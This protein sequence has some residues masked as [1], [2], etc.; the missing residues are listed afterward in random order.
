MLSLIGTA[1]EH[2]E[3]LLARARA[4]EAATARAG[5]SA[6]ALAGQWAPSATASPLGDAELAKQPI[7]GRVF[8][9]LCPAVDMTDL[10]PSGPP[11]EGGSVSSASASAGQCAA[12]SASAGS[13]RVGAAGQCAA[14]A[15]VGVDEDESGGVSTDDSYTY[16]YREEAAQLPSQPPGQRPAG[17]GAKQ[18]PAGLATGPGGARPAANARVAPTDFPRP[19]GWQP[20]PDDFS[21]YESDEEVEDDSYFSEEVYEVAAPPASATAAVARSAGADPVY[22]CPAGEEDA[23]R[24]D[25][26]WL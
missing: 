19:R 20:T 16:E 22:S 15:G 17:A 11:S 12:A 25:S 4:Q 7:S 23:K 9:Q 10:L 24:R 8:T 21:Y 18:Q 6:S 26:K 1:I 13:G 3:K 14:A 5:N 2:R